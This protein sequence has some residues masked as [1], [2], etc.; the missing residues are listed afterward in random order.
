MP[1]GHPFAIGLHQG[2]AVPGPAQEHEDLIGGDEEC[3]DAMAQLSRDRSVQ[4]DFAKERTLVEELNPRRRAWTKRVSRS[5]LQGKTQRMPW[6]TAAKWGIDGEGGCFIALRREECCD[7]VPGERD[8]Y[9]LKRA[10]LQTSVR[11]FAHAARGQ[12]HKGRWAIVEVREERS[13]VTDEGG[14]RA[15]L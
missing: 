5:A 8:A 2:P 9:S 1:L 11:H 7:G 14:A 15:D 3:D 4:R 12:A 10:S 13:V 6:E